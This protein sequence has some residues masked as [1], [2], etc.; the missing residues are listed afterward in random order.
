MT[1]LTYK[2]GM[3]RSVWRRRRENYFFSGSAG[4]AGASTL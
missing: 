2:P 3:T 4:A 1:N